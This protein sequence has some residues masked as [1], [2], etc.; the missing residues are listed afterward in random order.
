MPKTTEWK[1]LTEASRVIGVSRAKLSRL[2]KEGKVK[3]KLDP[4][5]GR[6]TL[7]D[8][9]QLKALFPQELR[10]RRGKKS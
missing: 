7:C 10:R 6:C 1:P 8:M 3:S 4:F 9:A 2:V 5:D